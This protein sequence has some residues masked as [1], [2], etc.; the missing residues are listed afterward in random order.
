[1]PIVAF[2]C[3]AC[4]LLF[5]ILEWKNKK[6]KP[7]RFIAFTI[8][9]QVSLMVIAINTNIAMNPEMNKWNPENLPPDWSAMRDQWY[10]IDILC[11]LF[12]KF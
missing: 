8:F 10:L 9:I 1:M 12:P 2:S 7:F 3:L 4:M 11:K 6:E 5:L